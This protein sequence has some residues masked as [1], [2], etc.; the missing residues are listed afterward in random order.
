MSLKFEHDFVDITPAP[1]FARLHG[2]HH[3]MVSASIMLGGVMAG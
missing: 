2:T 3:R 1:L